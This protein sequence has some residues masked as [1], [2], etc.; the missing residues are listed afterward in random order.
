[1]HHMTRFGLLACAMLAAAAAPASAHGAT[2]T[3][4]L[5]PCYVSVGPA[6]QQRQLAHI[7]ADGFTPLAPV[8]LIFDG[9]PADT[10]DD[11]SPNQVYADDRG[12]VSA[13]VR[14]PYQTDGERGF[15]VTVSERANPASALSATA[16]VT[17]LAVQLKPAQAAPSR[18]VRFRGRG[19]TRPAAI[20]GHYVYRGK[21]RATVR[22][23]RRPAGAC[24]TF[25]VRR[26]QIPVRKPHTGRWTLQV[27]QQ[28]RYS[29]APDSVF[30]RLDID[31]RRV[32]GR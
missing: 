6:P 20:W 1:M 15:T 29:V 32:I 21:V 3:Q 26:R 24:G 8:D 11:G 7:D 9:A 13:Q 16:R 5:A 14:V 10:N 23:A 4:P 19:F 27:D 30:V 28:R 31:V 2:W 22:L 17:A 25:S 18:R 12:H